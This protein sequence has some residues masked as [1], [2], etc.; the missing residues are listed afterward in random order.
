MCPWHTRSFP[1]AM[2]GSEEASSP[3][4]A[5]AQSAPDPAPPIPEEV[6]V[7]AAAPAATQSEPPSNKN[8]SSGSSKRPAAFS[9]LRFPTLDDAVFKKPF[10]IGKTEFAPLDVPMARR[11]QTLAVLIWL[12]IIPLTPLVLLILI[13]RSSTV[14]LILFLG[15]VFWIY[16]FQTFHVT[17][18]MASRPLKRLPFWKFFRD[19]FP[20]SLVKSVDLPPDR[21]YVFGYHPHGI[22]GVGAICNFVSDATGFSSLFP[23][24]NLRLLTLTTN[25]RIPFT[26]MMLG[27][28]GVADSSKESCDY[29]LSKGLGNSLMLVLGG[30]K[31]SLDAH[32]GRYDLTL[33]DRKGFV[34]IALRHGAALV[35]VFS[36]GENDIWDQAANP[37][38]SSLRKWQD[39][40][41]KKM[42]FAL[43]LV[44]G[45]GI[46]N[47]SVGLMPHRR[48]I[49]SV[50][51]RPIQLPR[52]QDYEITD[53]IINHYHQLYV[54]SL[55]EVFNFHK[56]KYAIDG[57]KAELRLV[58]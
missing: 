45:R 7:A 39:N 27:F 54:D 30:A 6:I 10:K 16:N 46:F 44:R 32:P 49:T 37:K 29:I 14:L 9:P 11:L 56:G 12:F 5:V 58:Q 28:L 13:I 15:Y 24:I 47:Y 25:F 8:N 20:I 48:R 41:T 51:G 22:I 18:G 31:E 40:L 50:V 55:F 36:F 21:P 42:G 19:Y 34:K 26:S 52:L 57:E 53:D 3:P 43:P 23:G 33:K 4:A 17:G 35:P 1:A 38:G 2:S